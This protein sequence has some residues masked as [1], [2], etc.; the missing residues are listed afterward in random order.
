MTQQETGAGALAH[1]QGHTHLAHAWAR[2]EPTWRDPGA[3]VEVRS[4]SPQLPSLFPP[5]WLP[6]WRRQSHGIAAVQRP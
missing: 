2:P 4:R 5:Q 6:A 3:V 1:G